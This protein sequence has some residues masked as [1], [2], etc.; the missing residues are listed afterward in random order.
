MSD[1][2]VVSNAAGLSEGERLLDAFIAPSKTFTDILRSASWWLPFV[3]MVVVTFVSAYTI[4]KKVGFDTVAQQQMTKSPAAS[5]RFQQMP[6]EQRARAI[7]MSAKYT[8]IFTYASF[9]PILVFVTIYTLLL[10]ASFNFGLGA[11]TTFWQVFATVMYAG[12]PKI[13][14]SILTIV[15][16]FS[17]VGVEGFDLQ[18]PVGTNVG[19]FVSETMP[20]LKAA[21]SFI[22]V[23]GLWSLAVLVLGMAI[24]SGKKIGSSAMIVVGWWVVGMLLLTGIAAA[25]G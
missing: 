23:F 5:D 11:R 13:F 7:S 15:L 17:G 25:F 2:V 19:Y 12:L 8:R 21:G 4:D 1:S 24:I 10:W 22:D 3:V 9:V 20:A 16:L 6:P 14:I 18:N